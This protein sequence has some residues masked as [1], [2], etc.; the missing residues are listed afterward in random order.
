MSELNEQRLDR[1]V[2]ELPESL[3]PQRDLWPGIKAEIAPQ[4]AG[5]GYWALAAV[6]ALTAV[7]IGFLGLRFW[8]GTGGNSGDLA[9][10]PTAG[11]EYAWVLEG[12]RDELRAGLEA[13]L[14]DLPAQDREAL[15][16]EL[17]GLQAAREDVLAALQRS[18]QNA[19]L[20]ELAVSTAQRE[21]VVMQQVTQLSNQVSTRTQ[22]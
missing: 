21:L 6:W 4:P 22:S 7:G 8:G 16:T 11:E 20:Q 3:T 14:K 2:S 12:T 10:W 17:S 9:I 13:A 5:S 1:A 15:A 19:L 18:P